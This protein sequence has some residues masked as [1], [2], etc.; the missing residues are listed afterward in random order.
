ME[1]FW[2]EINATVIA[3]IPKVQ[4]PV[5]ASQF[6]PIS[7]CN[8]IYKVISKVLCNRL[9]K[10]LP[11]LINQTQAAFVEGRSLVHNVLICHD[12][13]RHYKRKTTPR[14]MM[15]IDL[16]KAYDMV[17][18]K[19]VEEMLKGYGFPEK[20]C[21]WVMRCLTST[22]FS[23]RVN[24]TSHG[25]FAGKRGLRQGDPISPLLFVLVMEY[26]SRILLKMG[27]LPDFRF[28]PMCKK[29]RLNHLISADDLMIFCKGQEKSVQRIKE[30]LD[31]FS[32][33]TGLI[34]N[35]E[36]SSI[37]IAGV[38]EEV[39]V[40]LLELTGYT[41]GSFPIRYLGLPLSPRKWSKM[42]CNQLCQKIIERIRLVSNK[43][44][45]YAGR[46]QGLVHR[47]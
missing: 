10:V 46:V 7:C 26:L 14:C 8:V 34:A 18:W 42:E 4:N 47:Q 6:R 30:A 28:H 41:E 9:K 37:F 36:K 11:Y 5:L 20:F 39:K 12:I 2:D 31:H 24:G 29:L 23:V 38:S 16:R 40:R 25:Y 35:T 32:K 22:K 21:Q 15:K 13:M 17:N 1:F 44:L 3:V 19:F 43:H 27:Q 45:S 33:T